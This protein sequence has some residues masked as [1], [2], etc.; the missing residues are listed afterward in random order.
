MI[1]MLI[2]YQTLIIS[3]LLGIVGTLVRVALQ[4]RRDGIAPW[5]TDW[6]FHLSTEIFIGAVCGGVCWLI[7]TLTEAQP[8]TIV[9][10]ILYLAAL[11]LG[12]AGTDSLENLLKKYVP[13]GG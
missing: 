1:N 13:D 5:G 12:L 6:Q 11:A 9:V 7:Y 3:I 4:W 8:E 2:I 10:P